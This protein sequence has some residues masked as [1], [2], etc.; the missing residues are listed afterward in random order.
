MID[1][2]CSEY[3]LEKPRTY[4]K[5]AHKE[6]LTFAK[7]KKPSVDR[8]KQTIRHQLGYVHR[9]LEYVDGFLQQ[10]YEFNKKYLDD[11]ETIRKVYEQQKYTEPD[12]SEEGSPEGS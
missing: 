9:N 6:Y 5:V 7:S 11:L 1:W 8:I 3:G 2:F 10:G 4:R 12:D